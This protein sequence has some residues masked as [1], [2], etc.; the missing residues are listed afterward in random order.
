MN[1]SKIKLEKL[2]KGILKSTY[3]TSKLLA[4]VRCRANWMTKG[5]Q[6]ACSCRYIA[7]HIT[8]QKSVN[9]LVPI[10]VEQT[11]SPSAVKLFAPR[12]H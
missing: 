3:K 1:S 7:S 4:P 9:L 8:S 6:N 12:R 2:V 5:C 10:D 11:R